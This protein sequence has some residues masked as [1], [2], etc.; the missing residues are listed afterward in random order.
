MLLRSGKNARARLAIVSMVFCA[1]LLSGSAALSGPAMLS[2]EAT[3]SDGPTLVE[4][5]N[6]K[7]CNY[8]ADRSLRQQSQNEGL[9]CG[10]KGQS[11][12]RNRQSHK[13]WCSTPGIELP[14]LYLELRRREA[15]L[16]RCVSGRK[17]LNKVKD[18][19]GKYA[20]LAATQGKR[21]SVRLCGNG[22]RQW[23]T[24][25]NVHR[26]ALWLAKLDEVTEGGD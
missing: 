13:N 9:R 2:G 24:D 10:Y 19:C 1:L 6:S 17:R 21:N 3:G 8:Y 26:A 11:W 20:K 5:G 4:S 7:N 16:K 22:G 25:E 23:S 18:F 15:S 12:S 14:H